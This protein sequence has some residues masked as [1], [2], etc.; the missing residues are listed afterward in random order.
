MRFWKH[1]DTYRLDRSWKH[2]GRPILCF[3]WAI[4]LEL[5]IEFP[6]DWH[7]W[8]QVE[9]TIAPIFGHFQFYFPWHKTYPDHEQCSGPKFGFAIF[10]LDPWNPSLWLWWGNSDGRSATPR[11]S[12]IIYGP[13]DWGSAHR[14]DKEPV[15][16]EHDFSYTLKSGEVQNRKA[17]L[18]IHELEWHRW[19]LPWKRVS[20][21]IWVDFDGEVGER[22]GTWKGGTVGCG[23]DLLPNETPLE[24]FRRMES[25][26][27]FR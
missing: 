6:S 11:K 7:E 3:W 5:S 26:R 15:D 2:H 10:A 14:F 23:Y 18:E 25:E 12:A 21:G 22:T 4:G 20:R 8:R 17:K 1:G 24:C 19:W 13:W 16:G 9:V 27:E